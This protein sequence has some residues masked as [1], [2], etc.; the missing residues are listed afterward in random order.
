MAKSDKRMCKWKPDAIVKDLKV[1]K[2]LV[3]SP[4][5]VCKK[6]GRVANKKKSLHKPVAL[7]S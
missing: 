4:Q 3:D 5:Y 1:F 7:R 6:C 2:S